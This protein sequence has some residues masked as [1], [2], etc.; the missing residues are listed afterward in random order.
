LE[1]NLG[2]EVG[3][4]A[5]KGA[6]DMVAQRIADSGHQPD[7]SCVYRYRT[8]ALVGPWRSTPA[9]AMA[10]A[11]NAGQVRRDERDRHNLLWLVEGRI[12]ER[13]PNPPPAGSRARRI[14]APP[15]P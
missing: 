4:A 3:F 6:Q 2:Q 10:D 14:F 7:P 8:K 11:L 9:Q 5:F 12:E 1:L 13:K 15:G